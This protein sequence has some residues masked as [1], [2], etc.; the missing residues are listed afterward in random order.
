MNAADILYYGHRTLHQ[1][2]D[3]LPVSEWETGGVCGVWS[4]KD[5]V[6]HLASYEVVLVDVLTSLTDG[7]GPTPT[8]DRFKEGPGFNDVEVA[9]AQGLAVEEVLDAYTR[10]NE[11]VMALI[12]TIPEPSRSRPG[13]LPWYGA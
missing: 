2:L 6:A 12:A 9:A 5:I 7:G 11:R 3:D 1:A 4:V 10:T 13:T 8:L